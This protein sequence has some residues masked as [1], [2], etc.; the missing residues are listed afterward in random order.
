MGSLLSPSVGLRH[1][2]LQHHTDI[3]RRYCNHQTMSI[4]KNDPFTGAIGAQRDEDAAPDCTCVSSHMLPVMKPLQ[5]NLLKLSEGSQ[6][7][8]GLLIHGNGTLTSTQAARIVA[9]LSLCFFLGFFW[10]VCFA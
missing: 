7:E 10:F 8:H 1:S 9:H 5:L 2:T 4:G 3:R 6:S